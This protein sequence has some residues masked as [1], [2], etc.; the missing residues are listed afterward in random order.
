M[1]SAACGE[2]A[3]FLL[4]ADA[5]LA[6]AE[7][8]KI[9]FG[10]DDL[11]IF[12][13]AFEDLDAFVTGGA[14]F[15]DS[16]F[17]LLGVG[18]FHEDEGFFAFAPDG[19]LGNDE[20]VLEFE[21]DEFAGGVH[22]DFEDASEGVEI[23]DGVAGA[24]EGSRGAGDGGAV[25]GAALG[26]ARGW[27]A[28]GSALA[29]RGGGFFFF[30]FDADADGGD[31]VVSGGG[32][33][34]FGDGAT[35]G[36]VGEAFDDDSDGLVGLDAINVAFVYGDIHEEAADVG[37]L[38]DGG[39]LAEC[40]GTGR[41]D[42]AFFEE[43]LGDDASTGGDDGRFSELVAGVVDADAAT[44][45]GGLCALDVGLA[46]L[47][48]EAVGLGLSEGDAGLLDG[49]F[50]AAQVLLHGCA[51]AEV[52]FGL[53]DG[54]AG[55]VY[56]GLLGADCGVEFGV[57]GGHALL[58]DLEGREGVLFV[59]AGLLEGGGAGIAEFC[60]LGLAF[61]FAFG[62][63]VGG[64]SA[65]EVGFGIAAA[66][67]EVHFAEL[68]HGFF[69]GGEGGAGVGEGGFD[70]DGFGAGVLAGG[71]ELDLG[72]LKA[73]TCVA[74]GELAVFAGDLLVD[75]GLLDAGVGTEEIG[76][77]LLDGGSGV[78]GVNESDEVA[79]SDHGA[80]FDGEADDLSARF[81]TDV[82]G[83]LGND[84]AGR[85]GAAEEIPFFNFA[86]AVFDFFGGLGGVSEDGKGGNGDEAGGDIDGG[87]FHL[88][89][90]A[91]LPDGETVRAQ[92]LRTNSVSFLQVSGEDC[93]PFG[94]MWAV[95]VRMAR[96]RERE[97]G[98][99]AGCR[100]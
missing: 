56:A 12:L 2:A 10:D 86:V 48:V 20:D 6:F 93:F 90:Y 49:A 91:S 53:T 78:A 18:G 100:R 70:G 22:A 61:E 45:G 30:N 38:D 50:G 92:P 95:P 80:F 82:H 62:G 14:E 88:G 11:F 16:F 97:S 96:F 27:T 7:V 29:A 32:G 57:E 89:C 84:G 15:D 26:L 67:G 5:F 51:P 23:G 52:G 41:D 85:G 69:G 72:L 76:L 17:R 58:R 54:S 63:V 75:A 98:R 64:L 79:A 81:A 47:V 66:L 87:T 37:D 40:A 33:E 25:S 28:T 60:E 99:G 68:A 21:F 42:G 35:E 31:G 74:D 9:D 39:A 44:D 46:D 83:G 24:S 4:L 65:T 43:L 73:D 71:F 55:L 19:L 94:R 8:R 77:G 34:D 13:E 36:A 59:A 1:V 3:A